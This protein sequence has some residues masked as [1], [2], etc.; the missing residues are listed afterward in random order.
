MTLISFTATGIHNDKRGRAR[1]LLPQLLQAVVENVLVPRCWLLEHRLS[2][3]MVTQVL[4]QYHIAVACG[5]LPQSGSSDWFAPV[6]RMLGGVQVLEQIEQQLVNPLHDRLVSGSLCVGK[7]KNNDVPLGQVPCLDQAALFLQHL[8]D[9]PW[10]LDIP[11]ML[12]NL[13][14]ASEALPSGPTTAEIQ[15]LLGA[16]PP[17][18]KKGRKI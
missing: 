2:A 16:P 7:G 15:S 5:C 3:A 9:A 1:P 14:L 8:R 4:L 11:D 17:P 13:R 18:E 12:P 10:L 6:T